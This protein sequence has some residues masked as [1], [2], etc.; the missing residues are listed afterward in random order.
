ML[1]RIFMNDANDIVEQ[2]GTQMLMT[3]SVVSKEDEK[4]HEIVHEYKKT[5]AI[6]GWRAKKKTYRRCFALASPL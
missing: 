1:F 4:K 5:V 2:L 3:M 6:A